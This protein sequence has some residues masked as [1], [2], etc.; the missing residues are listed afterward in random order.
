MRQRLRRALAGDLDILLRRLALLHLHPTDGKIS[1]FAAETLRI[2][3]AVEGT[4]NA[5]VLLGTIAWSGTTPAGGHYIVHR[6]T[7]EGWETIDD[8]AIYPSPLRNK[9]GVRVPA[10]LALL[11]RRTMCLGDTVLRQYAA[12]KWT[13]SEGS[14]LLPPHRDD[15]SPRDLP[16][17][18]AE[19]ASANAEPSSQGR[20]GD[21]N[22]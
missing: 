19:L 9:S 8:S 11:A 17:T 18:Y 20:G 16:A 5:F 10:T 22:L 7:Q 13:R 6:R 4:D 15:G 14:R 12:G 1:S 21:Q 3:H 2:G